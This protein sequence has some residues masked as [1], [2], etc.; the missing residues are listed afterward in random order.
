[1]NMTESFLGMRR[2]NCSLPDVYNC[3]SSHSLLYFIWL[4]YHLLWVLNMCWCCGWFVISWSENWE[5]L[6]HSDRWIQRKGNEGKQLNPVLPRYDSGVVQFPWGKWHGAQNSKIRS[7]GIRMLITVL[8][9]TTENVKQIKVL[10][11]GNETIFH[12]WV[13]I[14]RSISW[15]IM[16]Q[17]ILTLWDITSNKISFYKLVTLLKKINC[18]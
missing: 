14:T 18:D 5:N 9:Y 11:V 8:G 6:S 13:I 2:E 4:A 12:D 1:M 7:S 15:S 3:D 17:Y 16:S 10:A